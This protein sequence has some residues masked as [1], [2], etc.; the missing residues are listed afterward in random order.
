[1]PYLIGGR[2]RSGPSVR[3][4]S[5]GLLDR[6]GRPDGR[7]VCTRPWASCRSIRSGRSPGCS[8]CR[9]AHCYRRFQACSKTESCFTE[10]GIVPYYEEY[11]KLREMWCARNCV[12]AAEKKIL[13]DLPLPYLSILSYITVLYKSLI[14]G[15]KGNHAVYHQRN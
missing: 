9:I 6:H 13:Y 4:S 14:F 3:S 5:D 1:M 7:R 2:V 11:P 12:H 15:S 10:Y 8:C